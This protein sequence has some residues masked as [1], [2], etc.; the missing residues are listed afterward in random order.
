MRRDGLP[1][2]AAAKSRTN[3]SST[4]MVERL[5]VRLPPRCPRVDHLPSLRRS[6]RPWD[7]PL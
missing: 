6:G 7:E 4:A 3:D 5:S 1:G 2:V